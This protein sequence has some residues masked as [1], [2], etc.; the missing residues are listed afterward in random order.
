MGMGKVVG[1]MKTSDCYLVSIALFCSI[2]CRLCSS[3]QVYFDVLV[4][5]LGLL[6]SSMLQAGVSVI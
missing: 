6:C 1:D 3:I 5:L 4:K 2:W